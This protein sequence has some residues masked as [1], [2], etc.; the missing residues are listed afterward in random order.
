MRSLNALARTLVLLLCCSPVFAQF[1]EPENTSNAETTLPV[2]L[3]SL[4]FDNGGLN[5]ETLVLRGQIANFDFAQPDTRLWLIS[6]GSNWELLAPS[7]VDLRRLGWTSNSVF[8]GEFVEVEVVRLLG[9]GLSA[10][11]KRLT[12]AN[13]ALLFTNTSSQESTIGFSAVQGGIYQLDADQAHL[14]FSFDHMGFSKSSVKVERLNGTVDWNA[15]SPETSTIDIELDMSSLRSGTSDLDEA[16]RGSS[17]FSSLS[18]P[19][20]SF[21]ST[22]LSFNKWG[23]LMVFG[24]LTIRNETRPVTLISSINKVGLNELTQQMTVGISLKSELNRSDWG[25]SEY[26]NLIPDEISLSF[27]GEF[28]LTTPADI[29]DSGRTPFSFGL[30]I[31]P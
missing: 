14:T 19:K 20:V 28:I 11:L 21:T 25:L 9:T 24:D 12:R 10:K 13:G 1:L 17:F 29:D 6:E 2:D 7:A 27:Q 31:A 30:P 16:L 3:N 5:E 22:S 23:E 18:Y 8:S 15:Q 4:G 26:L